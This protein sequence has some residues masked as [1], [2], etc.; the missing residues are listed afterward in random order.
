[1]T[2]DVAALADAATV[3]RTTARVGVA[4]R[5]HELCVEALARLG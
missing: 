3:I 2:D 5:V 4:G 1:M